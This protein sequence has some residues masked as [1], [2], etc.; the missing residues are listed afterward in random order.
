M[1][2]FH[3]EPPQGAELAERRLLESLSLELRNARLS[4]AR[5]G[6]DLARAHRELAAVRKALAASQAR[7]AEPRDETGR[8]PPGPAE[9]DRTAAAAAADEFHAPP[10]PLDA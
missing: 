3:P 2:A 7:E 6:R 1:S 4:V 8:H 9:P 5:F 10:G